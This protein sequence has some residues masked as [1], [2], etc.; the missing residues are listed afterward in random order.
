[1]SWVLFILTEAGWSSEGSE[2]FDEQLD[3]MRHMWDY[4]KENPEATAATV[5]TGHQILCDDCNAVI[6]RNLDECPCS[7]CNKVL[8]EQCVNVAPDGD[9]CDACEKKR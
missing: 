8:C 2:E 5:R 1:M 6:D 3:A 7:G 4:L 9:F